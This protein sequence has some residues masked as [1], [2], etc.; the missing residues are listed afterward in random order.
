FSPEE[1]VTV[2]AAPDLVYWSP[3]RSLLTIVDWKTGST[4]GAEEQLATYALY[5]RQRHRIPFREG[6]LRGRVVALSADGQDRTV[7]LTRDDLIAA[8]ARIRAGV[9]TMRGL[10]ADERTG[11]PLPRWEYPLVA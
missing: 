3:D 10:L 8:H 7:V 11:E 5:L 4:R 9:D 6:M 1:S 2:W